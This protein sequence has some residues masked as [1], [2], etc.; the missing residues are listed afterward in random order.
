M[1]ARGGL[2]RSA[3]AAAF[4]APPPQRKRNAHID[5]L[6]MPFSVDHKA[7]GGYGFPA[8][9]RGVALWE[10]HL[11]QRMHL[12]RVKNIKMGVDNSPPRSV[13]AGMVR[14]AGRRKARELEAVRI[15]REN[16]I[17]MGNMYRMLHEPPRY[18]M[19]GADTER[20]R[21]NKRHVSVERRELALKRLNEQ[22]Q[23]MLKMI[24]TTGP[25]IDFSR[26]EQDWRVTQRH[27]NSASKMPWVVGEL[28]DVP[29]HARKHFSQAPTSLAATASLPDLQRRRQPLRHAGVRCRASQPPSPERALGNSQMDHTGQ[30]AETSALGARVAPAE[31]ARAKGHAHRGLGLE[32]GPPH[33]EMQGSHSQRAATRDSAGGEFPASAS[34]E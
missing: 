20:G 7:A 13:A 23:K 18:S 32:A 9:C 28:P 4:I 31:G 1:P 5:H 25:D 6:P 27:M 11:D 29:E 10:M 14:E 8:A 2:G 15:A 17:L 30:Q 33:L 3:S 22:N 21:A 26:F 12:E 24:L 16:T 19:L 34:R